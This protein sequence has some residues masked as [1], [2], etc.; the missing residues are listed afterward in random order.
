MYGA[1]YLISS[2]QT[3][4]TPNSG[5]AYSNATFQQW[6]NQQWQ[7]RKGPQSMGVGNSLATIPFPILSTSYQDTI[8]KAQGQN[9]A[10]YLP[11]T[12]T[13]EN[14][15]GYTAQRDILLQSFGKRDNGVVEIPFSGG[16]TTSLVLEKPLSRGTVRLNPNDRYAEP[17]IDYNTNINPV[18]SDIM[19]AMVKF[20]RKWMAAPSMQQL[21]PQESRPGTNVQTDQQIAQYAVQGMSSSTAHSC[22]TAAMAPQDL[23]GVVSSDLTVYGV[24]GLSIGD[25]SIIPMIPATHT[26]A[27]VYAIAEKAA[28]LIKARYNPNIPSEP[29]TPVT[30]N[31]GN[32]A[33]TSALPTNPSSPGGCSVAKYGQCGGQSYAGCTTCAS[34]STCKFSNNWYSQCL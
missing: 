3:D 34:G 19:V 4:L 17:S 16:G 25:I 30:T 8:S 13:T 21:T 27:T 11:S 2:D 22:C 6:S 18:D 31:P 24:T 29:S 7:Q 9:A 1:N 12:Y 33:T 10:S 26:C 20:T 28:D 14:V 23:A 15:K 32:P 5:S